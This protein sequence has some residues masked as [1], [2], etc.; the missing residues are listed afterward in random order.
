MIVSVP[1]I[2]IILSS[3]HILNQEPTSNQW[4]IHLRLIW[5]DTSVWKKVDR[6]NN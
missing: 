5:L 4:N 1:L 6:T 2:I 3:A